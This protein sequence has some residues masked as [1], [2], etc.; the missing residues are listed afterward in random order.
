MRMLSWKEASVLIG[1]API[2]PTGATRFCRWIAA[3]MS[4]G[5]RPSPV[6]RSVSNQIRME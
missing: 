4:P 2:R 6:S 3:T 1:C 5:V